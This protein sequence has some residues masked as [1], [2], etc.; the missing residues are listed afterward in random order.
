MFLYNCFDPL[1]ADFSVLLRASFCPCE[2]HAVDI[3]Q[4]CWK[5]SKPGGQLRSLASAHS[6]IPALSLSCFLDVFP[7]L[8]GLGVGGLHGDDD[9]GITLPTLAKNSDRC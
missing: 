5:G 1:Y 8:T 2:L 6:D 7:Y 4:D 9:K 3:V